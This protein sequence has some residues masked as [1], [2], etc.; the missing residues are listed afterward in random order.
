MLT[1]RTAMPARLLRSLC[2]PWEQPCL[3]GCCDH[4]ANRTAAMYARS[5]WFALQFTHDTHIFGSILRTTYSSVKEA[6]KRRF[7]RTSEQEIQTHSLIASYY[8]SQLSERGGASAYLTVYYRDII[9]HLV[10]NS[11]LSTPLYYLLSG[12][13]FLPLHSIILP[14]IWWEIHTSLLHYITYYLVRNLYLSTPLYYLSSGE[15]FIPL[16][17][18]ILPIIW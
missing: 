4:Y 9:Y 2:W 12:E 11:Y 15:K 10:R 7:I 13:K 3:P 18:I 5:L 8:C 17:S 14:I 1:L 16:H 6:I